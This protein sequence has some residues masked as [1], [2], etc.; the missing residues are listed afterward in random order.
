ML[1]ICF[2]SNSAHKLAEIREI[3]GD[4]YAVKSLADIGCHEELPEEQT[5]LEGNSRQKAEYV[6]QKYGVNC[7]ADDTGLE[8]LALNMEPGVYSARYAGPQRSSQDNINLLLQNLSGKENR[9]AQ[10]RTSIT[11]ILDNNLFQFDGTVQGK[12]A[13]EP[14]GDQGFGYDPVFIPEGY[15]QTFAELNSGEKNK[16]SHRGRAV[17]QLVEY[18]HTALTDPKPL[19]ERL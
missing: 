17:Q 10:F 11:L 9:T 4:Q 14:Q 3:L 1:S 16:I 8:V 5:T 13:E 7:F 18:L 6:W 19:G 15:T 2:A 12:I